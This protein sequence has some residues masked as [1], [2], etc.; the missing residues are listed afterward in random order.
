MP[1]ECDTERQQE[2]DRLNSE[3]KEAN[4]SGVL[5]WKKAVTHR[6]EDES[7]PD[8]QWAEVERV[9]A[10]MNGNQWLHI[11]HGRNCGWSAKVDDGTDTTP[12]WGDGPT[13]QAAILAAAKAAGLLTEKSA[14]HPKPIPLPDG[15]SLP[16]G[17]E[18]RGE[19]RNPR[20][21]EW[22]FSEIDGRPYLATTTNS[23]RPI[24]YKLP[25]KPAEPK[26]TSL[27]EAAKQLGGKSNEA[28]GVS[29]RSL[30]ECEAA[31]A[32]EEGK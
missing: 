6:D 31:I 17:F 12:I 26:A 18:Y 2:I 15:Y 7:S 25:E 13:P 8:P 32:A 30:T 16:E 22:F 1:G 5:G 19:I 23:P 28:S 20:A 14:D 29:T 3:L 4:A 9:F 11:E 24:I 21:G 27:L 10:A